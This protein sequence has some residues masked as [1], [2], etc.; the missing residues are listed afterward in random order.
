MTQ[1]VLSN[2]LYHI[3]TTSEVKPNEAPFTGVLNWNEAFVNHSKPHWNSMLRFC[4][5]LTKDQILAE[6]LHQS[7]LLKA[8][9]AFEKF[10][11]SYHPNTTCT[12]EDIHALFKNTEVQYHFKNWLYKIAK[13]T[14]LD[15]LSDLQNWNTSSFED[16]NELLMNEEEN[17]FKKFASIHEDQSQTELNRQLKCEEDAFYQTT[18]D[19]KLKKNLDFLND[20][21]RTV[22]FLAAEDY[23]YKEIALIL[24]IPIGTVMSTLSRAIKK[25]KSNME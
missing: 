17:K 10:V 4:Y 1:K 2:Q 23:S 8:L 21:Q 11:V 25:L 13:N 22:I 18:L 7:A 15:S 16:M 24:E 12:A 5:S 20:R 14:Y 9:R 19:D 6:D 3:S